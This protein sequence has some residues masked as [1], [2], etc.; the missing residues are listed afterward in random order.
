M[1]FNMSTD[2]LVEAVT[3]SSLHV[4][5]GD[6]FKR[7]DPDYGFCELRLENGFFAEM[8]APNYDEPLELFIVCTGP[9]QGIWQ[10]VD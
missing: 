3:R 4:L 5:E 2:A 6:W 10:R 1:R 9:R 7:S 8:V